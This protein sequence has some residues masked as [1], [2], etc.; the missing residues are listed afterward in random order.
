MT[1]SEERGVPRIV[2]GESTAKMRVDQEV[3]EGAPPRAFP[4]RDSA[5]L[6]SAASAAA[7]AGLELVLHEKVD[8]RIRDALGPILEKQFERVLDK[9]E[10]EITARYRENEVTSRYR[11]PAESTV[12]GQR[13]AD[14]VARL[15]VGWIVVVMTIAAT[16]IGA[17]ALA[18]FAW[19]R[20]SLLHEQTNRFAEQSIALHARTESVERRAD[21]DDQYDMVVANWLVTEAST[22]YERVSGLD[23]M[24]RIIAAKIDADVTEVAAP[25]RTHPPAPIQ[26]KNSAFIYK[27][28]P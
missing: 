14:R 25:T 10:S 28:A 13:K 26:K 16:A 21:A 3:E 15:S 2:T 5:S 8:L 23:K 17:L 20:V 4:R 11:S 24:L 19:S 27:D 7:L 18:L 6:A 1:A 22:N 9:L 12:E